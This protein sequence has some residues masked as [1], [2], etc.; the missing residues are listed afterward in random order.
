MSSIPATSVEE[1]RSLATKS[2]EFQ[3]WSQAR[4]MMQAEKNG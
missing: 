2:S 3:M 4:E 1:A